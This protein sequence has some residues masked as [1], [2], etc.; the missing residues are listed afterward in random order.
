MPLHCIWQLNY[1]L[2][3]NHTASKIFTGAKFAWTSIS[4]FYHHRLT[5]SEHFFAMIGSFHMLTWIRERST[6]LKFKFILSFPVNF[7]RDL[8]IVN[9]G[10]QQTRFC[11]RVWG[12]QFCIFKNFTHG[13]WHSNLSQVYGFLYCSPFRNAGPLYYM[14]IYN[15]YNLYIS[16]LQFSAKNRCLAYPPR[17]CWYSYLLTTHGCNPTE[18]STETLPDDNQMRYRGLYN[19]TVLTRT[20]LRPTRATIEYSIIIFRLS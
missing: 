8:D 10:V 1:Q 7:G 3:S 2:F 4:S 20:E 13:Q 11:V 19:G 5:V 16:H 9:S 12:F 15:L 6:W 18:H 17:Y 14:V